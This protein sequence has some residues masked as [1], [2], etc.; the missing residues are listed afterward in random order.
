MS[1]LFLFVSLLLLDIADIYIGG[2]ELI[3]K[4]A[5]MAGGV[6]EAVSNLASASSEEDDDDNDDDNDNVNYRIN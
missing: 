5:E 1:F 6:G 4:V 2:V 3:A